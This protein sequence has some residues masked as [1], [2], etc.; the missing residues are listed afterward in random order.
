MLVFLIIFNVL[1]ISL[2]ILIGK[3]IWNSVLKNK[4]RKFTDILLLLVIGLVMFFPVI[5][6]DYLF[7][8]MELM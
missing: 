2:L 8:T 1:V 7:I 5:L 4:K 6:I 3:F